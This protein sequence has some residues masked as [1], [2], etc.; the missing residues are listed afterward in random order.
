M[1]FRYY[2]ACYGRSDTG[3]AVVNVSPNIPKSI[4]DDFAAIERGNAA[5]V[6]GGPVPMGANET[7]SCMLELYCKNDALGLVRVQYHLS[8]VEGRPISFAH[9]Y[10]FPDSYNLLKAPE[11]ILS[12]SRE[13]FA[14]QR[15]S[16]EEKERLRKH[17][18]ALIRELMKRS[19]P[20][21][22]PENFIRNPV[23]SVSEALNR[24]GLDEKSYKNWIIAVYSQ[25]LTTNTQ[26]NIYV[27][28]DGSEEY[29]LNLLYLT[30]L[31]IPYSLRPL[32]TGSTYLRENQRNTKLIFCA[33]LPAG[34]PQYNPITGETNAF[35]DVVAKRLDERNPIISAAVDHLLE[36]TD[37]THFDLIEALLDEMADSKITN[38]QSINLAY[39]ISRHEYEL[40]E[41]LPFILY[42]WL[43]LPVQ[44][45]DS[46]EEFACFLF[47][48]MKRKAIQPNAET[49]EILSARVKDAVTNKFAERARSF[50][51]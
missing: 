3:W 33:E 16:Q 14:D 30:Y 32:V 48:E 51:T 23:P 36:G 50:L 21:L 29:A 46:W 47:E 45:N 42:S 6:S 9:G 8:D 20:D 25:V 35:N 12:L 10:I 38:M 2:Q 39:S 34:V 5:A 44:N 7:P 1:E 22:T 13:N 11:W 28:T 43:A 4:V 37:K 19:S 26:K 40:P 31:A 27:K 15:L 17:P 18:G 24:C 41:R 49:A